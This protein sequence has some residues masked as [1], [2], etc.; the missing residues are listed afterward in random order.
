MVASNSP[1][2]H[3]RDRIKG[4]WS[5]DEDLALHRLVAK[6]GARNWSLISKGIPGR[7]G[8]SCRLR[9]CNQLSPQ[10]EHRPFT[11]QE[12]RTI[13]E[14]HALHGN[15]WATIARLLPGRTDNAIK[16][17]WNS[18]LRRRC[19][20]ENSLLHRGSESQAG[21]SKSTLVGDEEG[22]ECVEEE[23]EICSSFDNRKRIIKEISSNDESLQDESSS[24]EAI[25]LR[26]LSFSPESPVGSDRSSSDFNSSGGFLFKPVPRPSAFLLYGH[27]KQ[28]HPQPAAGEACSST[29][30]T[31]PITSLSLSLPGCALSKQQEGQ[32][33]LS[34]AS[35]GSNAYCPNEGIA[36]LVEKNVC[37]D[38]T[39]HSHDDR[40]D[41][42]S[43]EHVGH[44]PFSPCVSNDVVN[45][46]RLKQHH[47]MKHLDEGEGT[48]SHEFK[49]ALLQPP[50]PHTPFP[51]M[52]PLQ[53][54]PAAFPLPLQS[55]AFPLLKA[56]S[57]LR[58]ED[59]ME[60]ISSAVKA[61]VSQ[62]LSPIAS[63]QAT[64]WQPLVTGNGGVGALN[65]GLLA[66]MKDMVS[67]EVRTYM[68][69][70]GANHKLGVS[71]PSCMTSEGL[72]S[73]LPSL[74]EHVGFGFPTPR[75]TTRR[76]G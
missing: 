43:E 47:D 35:N 60:L 49:D 25:K 11:A 13:M 40:L 22:D 61:A 2:P 74:S 52:V 67:Q 69:S 56:G 65:T 55:P 66:L 46:V 19:V 68:A 18:T 14:A 8:K 3:D 12:D 62:V 34:H 10:V 42:K 58:A 26:K 1:L 37:Y 31:D 50:P 63:M 38:H 6:Y 39:M 21:L 7:S 73:G 36:S 57:Y 15:K 45:V 9:W 71:P 44:V 72:C 24:W 20:A 70:H 59:V 23:E 76:V 32:L 28:Q 30:T 4:P 16:N 33:G 5:P 51:G 53:L 29:T 64:A 48:P 75:P 27:V 41:V 54:P 17:H